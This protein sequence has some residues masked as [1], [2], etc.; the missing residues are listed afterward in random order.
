M[1]EAKNYGPNWDYNFLSSSKYDNR[2]EELNSRIA[3]SPRRL[4]IINS[5]REKFKIPPNSK[6][7]GVIITSF[8]EP[9]ISVPKGFT[10][11]NI[12]RLSKVF[13]KKVTMP[14][15]KKIRS[16]SFLNT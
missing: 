12:D 1:I 11:I 2:V 5:D 15:W 4:D 7:Q 3:L 10:C 13:G 8:L 14:N 6:L 16:Y 9:H